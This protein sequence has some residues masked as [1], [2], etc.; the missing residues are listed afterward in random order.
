MFL[1]LVLVKTAIRSTT[2]YF[3]EGVY[4]VCPAT[5]ENT[6]LVI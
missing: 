3:G 1:D 6:T 4:S 5:W 2:K